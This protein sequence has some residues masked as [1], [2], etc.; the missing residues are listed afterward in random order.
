[1]WEQE[2]NI[3][4]VLKGV[5]LKT[6]RGLR[7]L[8]HNFDVSR[9][10]WYGDYPDPVTWLDLFRSTDGN[11]DG[12]FAS[13]KYDSLLDEAGRETDVG[14]RFAILKEAETLLTDQEMPFLPLYQYT[15]GYMYNPRKVVGMDMNVRM[16]T[17]M[18]FLHLAGEP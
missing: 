18:K 16:L 3:P 6:Y 9:A 15:D 13:A 4:V 11:N 12:K 1:M 5:D 17:E 10:G 14:K 2:L 8:D 7:A